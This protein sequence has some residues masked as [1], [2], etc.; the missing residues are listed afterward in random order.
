MLRLRTAFSNVCRRLLQSDVGAEQVAQPVT[1]RMI[2]VAQALH[3]RQRNGEQ[4]SL[5]QLHRI[6]DL[7]QAEALNVIAQLENE[8][9]VQIERDINDAFE[10]RITVSEAASRRFESVMEQGGSHLQG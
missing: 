6:C 10:S 9:T 7:N 1:S 8:G 3:A 5:R 2:E 4:T